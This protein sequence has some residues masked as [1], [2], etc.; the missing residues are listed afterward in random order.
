MMPN[1]AFVKIP[2]SVAV[3]YVD[4]RRKDC[5]AIAAYTLME[6]RTLSRYARPFVGDSAEQAASDVVHVDVRNRIATITLDSPSNRNA[7]SR[8]LLR[9][10]HK[11]LDIAEASDAR[12]IV[13]GH[14][15][16][17]F[18]AG[19]DLKERSS[20]PP[21]STPMVAAMRR[22]M[23]AKV[24]TI[25]AVRGSVRAGGIGLM[26]S[27]DLVVVADTVDFAFTEV[28]IGVA[29]A[30]ISVPI[31]RRTTA[32]QIRTS[33]LTGERFD[34]VHAHSIG[35]V[36]HVAAGVDEV[37]PLVAD[38]C[39]RVCAGA[40]EAVAAT[41]RLLRDVPALG[42][43]DAFAEMQALSEMLFQS[44]EAAEGMAAFLEKRTPIWTKDT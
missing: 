21:D 12:V 27:C 19:A 24:P 13:V 42:R 31:L 22:L 23:D 18:C 3:R 35:L 11:A 17:A 33:F 32:S 8:A 29:P 20:S 9:D 1:T 7:L 10:L 37:G 16:P 36:T 40:P 26:A 41:K 2:A 44:D 34:A 38:L 6:R 30:I 43:D 5:R 15:G 14:E 39:A 28:R 25:A 4:C